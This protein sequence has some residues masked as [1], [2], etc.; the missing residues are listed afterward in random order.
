MVQDLAQCRAKRHF[1][2]LWLAV[3]NIVV[4]G[5]HL[6]PASHLGTYA[7][8]FCRAAAN[9]DRDVSQRLNAVYGSRLIPQAV[10][11]RER[12]SL[13]WHTAPSLDECYLDGLFAPHKANIDAENIDGAAK[14]GP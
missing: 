4:D 12:W 13:L 3:G 9:D 2:H 11:S 6:C 1:N 7:C 5:Q 14:L 8:E 10:L